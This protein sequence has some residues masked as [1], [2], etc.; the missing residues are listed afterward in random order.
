MFAGL[1]P[2]EPDAIVRLMQMFREDP[3][4]DRLDLGVGVYRDAE[5]RT[6]VMRAVTEAER[7][8]LARQET[9][10]YTSLTGEPAFLAAVEQLVFAGAIPSDRLAM[11]ATTGG[12]GALRQIMELV[13]MV[14]PGA[15]LHLPRP[16]WANHAPIAR[17]VG[18]RMAEYRY[19]DAATGGLDRAGMLA[20]LDRVAA[21]DVVLLHGACHNPTGVDPEPGDWAEIG[22][23][24]ARRRAVPL[25]DLA[26][27]GLGEGL[28]ADAGGL[29]HLCARLPEALVA[30][31]GS[32]SFGL[33]RERVGVA[34]A[35]TEGPGPRAAVAAALAGLNRQAFAFPP[36]HGARVV[37]EIL[38]DP[39]LRRDLEAELAG[40]RARIGETRTALVRALA[41]ETGSDRF[42]FLG[43]QKGMFAL[44]PL[45]PEQLL[46]LREEH[47]IYIVGDGRANVA[48]L[49]PGAI[50]RFAAALGAVLRG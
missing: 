41:R 36:D 1:R 35:V 14:A 44:L 10:T 29:R 7:R 6:P 2:P 21:G 23:V 28:D 26:Y 15:T 34:M 25:I 17:A 18:L 27:L 37:T 20:D 8:I 5:G 38:T 30:V 13:R 43:S 42:G 47:A 39:A 24:L 22:A 19:L 9:K 40:M 4:P 46:R 49:P 31:S 50:D 11:A 12:T 3:R 33:Y 48:G 32:K 45:T 16:T